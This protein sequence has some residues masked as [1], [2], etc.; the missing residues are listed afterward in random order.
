[1]VREGRL[2]ELVGAAAEIRLTV[3]RVDAPLLDALRTRARVENVE[4][5]TVTLGVDDVD[6]AP[7]IADLVVR[8]GYRLHGLVPLHRTLED[9]FVSLVEG[10]EP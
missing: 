8:G 4:N 6:L 7:A 1:V 2:D 5:T 3:D 10:R 9:V